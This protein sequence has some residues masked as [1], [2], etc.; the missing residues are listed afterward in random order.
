MTYKKDVENMIINKA[1]VNHSDWRLYTK[2]KDIYGY[3]SF[4][5][6]KRDADNT[7]IFA[8]KNVSFFKYHFR[9]K[10]IIK[11]YWNI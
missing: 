7:V 5:Y 1:P 8:E 2:Y 3:H 11:K 4:L 9:F 10:T 6:A